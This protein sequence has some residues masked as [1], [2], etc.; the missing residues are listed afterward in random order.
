MP[1]WAYRLI[2]GVVAFIIGYVWGEARTMR[3]IWR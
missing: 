1:D 3:R 2:I